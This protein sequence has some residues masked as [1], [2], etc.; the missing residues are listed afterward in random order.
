MFVPDKVGPFR[1]AVE[2]AGPR[3]VVFRV[4][5]TIQLKSDVIVNEPFLTIAGQTAPGGGIQLKDHDFTIRTHDVIVRYLRVRP[6]LDA[7]QVDPATN[8]GDRI[9]NSIL[10]WGRKEAP[11]YNVVVDHCEAW[12]ANDENLDVYGASHD[13]TF[14]WNIS[15]EGLMYSHDTPGKQVGHS[16]GS[17]IGSDPCL[18]T[19]INVSI[20]GPKVA[21]NGYGFTHERAAI[22]D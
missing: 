8:L 19:P 5:G 16:M 22:A 3:I 4:G 6:G 12:W 15:A 11:A 17:L 14:Q 2:A 9:T 7:V 10:V 13:V 1:A 18:E 21:P 20:D